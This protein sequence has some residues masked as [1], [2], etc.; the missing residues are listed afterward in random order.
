MQHVREQEQ[1]YRD[2]DSGVKYLL[3]GPRIDWGVILVKPGQALGGH[4]HEQVEEIFYFVEGQGVM[5]ANGQ[6]Y[7][8]SPG[9]VFRMEPQDR[10]DIRNDGDAPL[11]LIFI[12][13]PYAPEDKVSL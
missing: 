11:K 9:D 5:V 7:V 12:K 13:C 6:E 3:R 2:G 8:A 10:H 4:Y 1:P